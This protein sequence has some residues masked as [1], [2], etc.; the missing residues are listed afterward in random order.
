MAQVEII[1]YV[2]LGFATATLIAL[3]LG[4]AL[5]SLAVGIGRRRAQRTSPPPAVAELQAERNRLRAEYAMLSRR[6]E[7]RLED[8][9]RQTAEH[10]AEVARSRNRVDRLGAE[11]DKRDAMLGER[12]S[13]IARLKDQVAALVSELEARTAT[14]GELE[15][16][17][18]KREET[19]AAMSEQLA[20][21]DQHI[22]R[23]RTEVDRLTAEVERLGLARSEAVS[24]ERTIQER[25]RGRIED[26][27][28]LSRR[29]E[30]QRRE[31]AAQQSRSLALRDT[32]A[33]QPPSQRDAESGGLA[34][35]GDDIWGAGPAD[36][37]GEAEHG[38]PL[39]RRIED[40]DRQASE[41]QR[42][43]DR[44]D[45]VWTAK[46]ADVARAVASEPPSPG[47]D[48]ETPLLADSSGSTGHTPGDASAAA[49]A[50]GGTERPV[51]GQA[52]VRGADD[53]ETA[54]H[55]TEAADD[56]KKVGSGLANV[57]SLAQRIR[58]LQRNGS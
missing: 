47:S 35:S 40:A 3:L 6:V 30:V 12:D 50:N 16:E 19:I 53:T 41:L 29:I 37:D 4:G 34:P 52:L 58:A 25:V 44:L 51:A 11:V 28:D 36:C 18:G 55:G 23:L 13:E 31:L 57:I 1:M 49:A 39:E 48:V 21:R 27:T 22:E 10:M 17:Q 43:L 7:V 26:L 33:E 42:E 38:P 56:D 2:A 54:P 14:V 5:W 8:L 24:R 32:M 15:T 9:K 20:E 46:L 45:E